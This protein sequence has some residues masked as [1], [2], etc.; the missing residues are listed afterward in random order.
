MFKSTFKLILNNFSMV[1]KLLLYKIIVFI[2][3]IGLT[4]VFCLPI[5]N[6]LINQNF[7]SFLQTNLSNM[8][9]NFNLLE[10]V[11]IIILIVNKFFE[12]VSSSG[13]LPLA[14]VN[15]ILLILSYYY[16]DRLTYLAVV[17]DVHSFMSSNLKLGFMNCYISNFGKSAKLGLVKLVT[18]FI[19]DLI[20]IGGAVLIF[21][22]LRSSVYALAP[23]LA[24]LYIVLTFS[25][26]T[27][28][29]A[30]VETSI[31]VNNC[32]IIQAIKNNFRA[33]S[34]KFVSIFSNSLIIT[35]ILLVINMFALFFTFGIALL[36]TVPLSVLTIIIFKNVAYYECTGMR[37]YA[38]PNTI[39]MP[40]KLEEQDKFKNVIDII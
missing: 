20:I 10:L 18:T 15:Q 16:I 38:D 22:G 7:F 34:K 29:L 21:Y 25:L 35:T 31:V 4:T 13:L 24:I 17:D 39:M 8:F 3:L 19:L 30:G 6:A 26:K 1:W 5:I 37:Y 23:I 14:I 40:K 33:I 12:I 9:L 36:I 11:N 32:G 28:L 27:S 2:C